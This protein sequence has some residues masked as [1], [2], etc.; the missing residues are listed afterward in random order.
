MTVTSYLGYKRSKAALTKD[1]FDRLSAIRVAKQDD[2]SDYMRHYRELVRNLSK[3]LMF[4]EATNRFVAGFDGL[5]DARISVQQEFELREFYET[6][7]LPHL[8]AKGMALGGVDAILPNSPAAKYLQYHYIVKN[9]HEAKER[10]QLTDAGDG[11]DYSRAHARFQRI[12]V[13]SVKEI[14]FHDFLIIRPETLEVVYTT[15]KE[16]DLGTSFMDGPLSS[17][18]LANAIRTID[19]STDRDTVI[20]VDF[21]FYAP[22]SGQPAFFS[23]SPIV[24]NDKLTGILA[25]QISKDRMNRIVN[26]SEKNRFVGLGSTGEIVLFGK[27]GLMRN[28]SR[29][30]IEDP[31]AFAE[32]L[33]A[34]GQ[35][36]EAVRKMLAYG[37]CTII[38]ERNLQNVRMV[39]EGKTQTTVRPNFLGREIFASFSPMEIEGLDWAIASSIE[40]EEALLPV[41]TFLKEALLASGIISTL[42]ILTAFVAAGMLTSP[43]LRLSQAARSYAN[44][45]FDVRVKVNS[46][47]EV[48]DLAESLNRMASEIQVKNDRYLAKVNEHRRLLENMMPAS[49]LARLS[50][51]IDDNGSDSSLTEV[52]L[53]FV[54]IEGLERLFTD[55]PAA[56]AVQ[57]IDSLIGQFDE[58]AV[59]HGVE[60]LSSSGAG[61]LAAC[62]LNLPR[63]DHTPRLLAF[64]TEL[65]WI[66]STFNAEHIATL[67]LSVGVHRGPVTSGKLGRHAFVNELW[68]LTI[69]LAREIEPN[70]R[71]SAV[72]VSKKVYDRVS[73]HQEFRFEQDTVSQDD[74]AWT[75]IT[76]EASV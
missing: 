17:T 21:D 50:S 8:S 75:L 13:D 38:V 36:P 52:T 27:D 67:H 12:L 56:K 46:H 45:F 66:V 65:Q 57:M 23:V 63:Y 33:L 44:G 70:S 58:A 24:E 74:N 53:G 42:T 40:S 68:A 71:K 20:L 5:R 29:F 61:Y 19:E 55:F 9:P 76:F 49:V 73:T 32:Q 35:T 25:L 69:E 26:G 64:A 16:I 10:L 37:T 30:F 31:N 6:E 62:G 1:V 3:N 43:L 72:R 15:Q 4:V 54:E 22:S 18:K 47:D 59:R 41:S 28:D 7:V 11:S 14:E 60:K 51:A 48:E 2:L 39:F 34:N